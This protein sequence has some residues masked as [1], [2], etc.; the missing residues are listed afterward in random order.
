MRLLGFWK[1]NE[2]IEIE[3]EKLDLIEDSGT[4]IRIA[5]ASQWQLIR[6][7][8]LRHKL[9]VV[10]LIALIFL[11]LGALFAEF[12]APFN[13]RL[14]HENSQYVPP[15]RLHFVDADGVFHLRPFIY[16]IT[17]SIDQETLA[18]IYSE[19]RSKIH[20][21]YLFVHGDPYQLWG[22]FSGNLHLFGTKTSAD[23][24][25]L[26]TDRMGRDLLSL[27][28]H[29]SRISLSIGLVGIAI[30]FLLGILIGG[31][32]GYYGGVLDL[33]IQ[34]II[35]FFRSVPTLPLWMG[36]SA[37]LPPT[38]TTIQ[39]YFGI[40][41][42]LSLVGWTDLAR[43]VR[44]KFMAIK[45]EDFIMAAQLDGCSDLKIVFRYL[46]PSFMSYNI[47]VLTL[48]IPDM[49]LGETALSFIGLG[50]QA[51]AISWGVLLSDAQRIQVLAEAPWLLIP[52]A[53]VVVAI[54][55]FNFVGDAL[56]DAA[57]PYTKV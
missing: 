8:F 55:S 15:Q 7:K 53:F 56:R 42:I 14:P 33:M 17:T 11:Y 49:I 25:L 22:L 29:G 50:L 26:G 39:I 34:R 10:A 38:W 32:S 9:A 44:G 21:I 52:G 35:E 47:A 6:W 30:T 12:L 45:A 5:R 23:F 19:D 16:E 18:T 13:P 40:V 24:F 3:Q 37:A 43:V 57:D 41:M 4:V 31:I 46:L 36:L 28:I 2:E 27:I 20:P 1:K 48:W 54:L 51:P